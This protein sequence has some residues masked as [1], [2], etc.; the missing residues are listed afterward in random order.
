KIHPT[1]GAT[2]VGA[3]PALIAYNVNLATSDISVA[4]K[5][6]KVVRFAGGGLRFVKALGFEL[7]DRG[8][9]QVSMNMVNFEGTPLFRAFELVKREA[10]RYGVNVLASE[11][12]GLVPQ[13][14]LNACADFYLR[15]ENF[16]EEQ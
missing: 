6:A 3:R 12:V 8:I 1:A 5:I 15:L 16:N 10:E 7:K 4:K 11:I 9:V 13:A 2:V 14:A